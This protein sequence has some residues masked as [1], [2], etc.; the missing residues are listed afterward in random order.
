MD[1]LSIYWNVRR[2]INKFQL[3]NFSH[4]VLSSFSCIC[5]S[6]LSNFWVVL[7]GKKKIQ[8]FYIVQLPL[9]FSDNTYLIF[10]IS[11]SLSRISCPFDQ[12][13]LPSLVSTVSSNPLLLRSFFPVAVKLSVFVSHIPA[14]S[15]HILLVVIRLYCCVIDTAVV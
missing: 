13:P 11:F 2:T 4:L 8:S 1:K 15:P 5:L 7:F 14:V 6:W 9:Q 3:F 12:I 10:F